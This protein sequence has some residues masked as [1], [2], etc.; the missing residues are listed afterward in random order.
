MAS[1]DV[2][3]AHFGLWGALGSVETR[4][5]GRDPGWVLEQ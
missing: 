1:V 4:P 3:A 2:W 5:L